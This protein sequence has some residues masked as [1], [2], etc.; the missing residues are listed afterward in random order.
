MV[1]GFSGCQKLTK[2]SGLRGSIIAPIKLER[3]SSVNLNLPLICNAIF[4]RQ[5]SHRGSLLYQAIL[6]Q[7]AFDYSTLTYVAFCH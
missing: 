7:N 6:Y 2:T 4:T 3:L 1:T 5:T